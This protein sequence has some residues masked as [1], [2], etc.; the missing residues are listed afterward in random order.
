MTKVSNM[1]LEDAVARALLFAKQRVN[2]GIIRRSE[3]E[4]YV[5]GFLWSE[6]SRQGVREEVR[7][8]LENA[9]S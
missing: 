6:H 3:I 7:R 9:A 8:Q 1:S 5:L 2:E 4:G